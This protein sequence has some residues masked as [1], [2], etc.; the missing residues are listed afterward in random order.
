M[1]PQIP[2]IV[3]TQHALDRFM[4]RAKSDRV[5]KSLNKIER[6]AARA[7]KIGPCRY[8]AGGWILI[9][10]RGAIQTMFRPN[11]RDKKRINKAKKKLN[12]EKENISSK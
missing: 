5:L 4:E 1:N 6:L 10:D 7:I 11:N 3:L 9:H 12:C 2:K 8:Y